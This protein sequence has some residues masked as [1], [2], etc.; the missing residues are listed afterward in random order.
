VSCSSKTPAVKTEIIRVKIPDELLIVPELEKPVI[1]SANDAAN[2]Y[3]DLFFYADDLK[4]KLKSIKKLN[5]F[6]ATA[7]E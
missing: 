3:I 1:N 6:N 4:I 2:A 5:D 7:T